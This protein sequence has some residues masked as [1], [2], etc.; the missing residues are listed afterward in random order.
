MG[1]SG[2]NSTVTRSGLSVMPASNSR[3][4]ADRSVPREP[5]NGTSENGRFSTY[6]QA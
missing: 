4:F 2:A 6:R 1:V 3:D 5:E